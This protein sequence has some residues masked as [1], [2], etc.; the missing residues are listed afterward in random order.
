M[1]VSLAY[2]DAYARSV[3]ARVVATDG[4]AVLLNRTVFYPGGGGQPADAGWLRTD[5]GA[6][7]RVIGARKVGDEV[8][9]RHGSDRCPGPGCGTDHRVT[10]GREIDRQED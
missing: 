4:D 2:T 9:E 3:P 8:S 10:G 5:D 6:E 7:W 1:S